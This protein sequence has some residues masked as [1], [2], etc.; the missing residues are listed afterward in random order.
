MRGAEPE[1]PFHRVLRQTLTWFLPFAV[2]AVLASLAPRQGPSIL[3]YEP[4]PAPVQEFESRVELLLERHHC[5]TRDGPD[6]VIPGHAVVT[7][8]G[9]VRY[10]GEQVTGH[11]L[12]QLFDG[13]DH[14]LVVHGFCR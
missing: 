2:L 5:W 9:R 7:I 11:A 3:P 8:D 4:T 10:V 1:R 6:G 14:G 12:E 13:V